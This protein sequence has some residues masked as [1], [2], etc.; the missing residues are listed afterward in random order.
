M[1]SS[2]TARHLALLGLLTAGACN[3]E[4]NTL[5][6][7]MNTVDRT[8][9]EPYQQRMPKTSALPLAGREAMPDPPQR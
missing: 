7:S 5:E 4:P 1:M 2:A 9:H 8:T 6:P 3:C